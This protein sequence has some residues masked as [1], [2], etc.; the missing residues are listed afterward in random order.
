MPKFA[1][2]PESEKKEMEQSWV[3]AYN[4]GDITQDE[5]LRNLATLGYN[6]TQIEE[7]IKNADNYP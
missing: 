5:L 3:Y 4:M 6:A 7:V 2:L 1:D